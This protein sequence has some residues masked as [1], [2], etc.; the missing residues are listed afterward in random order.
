MTPPDPLTIRI[1]PPAC[2]AGEHDWSGPTRVLAHGTGATPTCIH[3]GM[4]AM[5]YDVMVLP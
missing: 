2:P 1:C 3:C 5:D 4:S